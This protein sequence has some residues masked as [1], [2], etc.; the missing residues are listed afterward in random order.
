MLSTSTITDYL[1]VFQIPSAEHLDLLKRAHDKGNYDSAS[2]Q[3]LI[4][5]LAFVGPSKL[6]QTKKSYQVRGPGIMEQICERW[7]NKTVVTLYTHTSPIQ[8]S[9][10]PL[11]HTMTLSL[12]GLVTASCSSDSRPL[13]QVNL[14]D[15]GQPA[16]VGTLDDSPRIHPTNNVLIQPSS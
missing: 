2:K 16:L 7:K 13:C 14:R 6:Q 9:W 15:S 12:I 5:S 10:V 4:G 11:S 3:K 8:S 1:R